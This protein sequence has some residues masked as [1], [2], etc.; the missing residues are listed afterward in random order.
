MAHVCHGSWAW[1]RLPAWLGRA[2][3]Y[4]IT[5][6]ALHGHP[7]KT[8]TLAVAPY[9]ERWPWRL[10]LRV[11]ATGF[12]FG[13][14]PCYPHEFFIEC[15]HIEV[16]ASAGLLELWRMLLRVRVPIPLHA[17]PVYSGYG[18]FRFDAIDLSGLSINFEMY[19]GEFNINGFARRL[20]EGEMR[21]CLP[22]GAPDPNTLRV[23]VAS[24]VGL[25]QTSINLLTGERGCQ[26]RVV[27]R[28]G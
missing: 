27:L 11:Y 10:H 14:P 22:R 28:R 24:A 19:R 25:K 21:S 3:T 17:D 6:F 26:P 18:V 2:F 15:E 16:A 4:V 20:A 12:G 1:V 9:L 23:H 5:R 13:N 8:R 7:L